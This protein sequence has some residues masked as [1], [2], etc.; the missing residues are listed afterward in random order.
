MSIARR[1]SF[2]WLLVSLI[3]TMSYGSLSSFAAFAPARPKLAELPSS[4][5]WAFAFQ[6]DGTASQV[7]PDRLLN[8]AKEARNWLTYSGGY[9][10]N[11]YSG[12]TQ[13]TPANV[14]NLEM[15]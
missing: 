4:E 1:T 7:G 8:A 5:G 3:T 14:K 13:I 10:S 15:K 9:F 12:L 11:R 2:T 6:G